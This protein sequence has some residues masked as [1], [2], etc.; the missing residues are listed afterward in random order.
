MSNAERA[1]SGNFKE[2]FRR[3]EYVDRFKNKKFFD[4][5][6]SPS[7]YH[8]N[9]QLEINTLLLIELIFRFNYSKA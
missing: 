1:P 5:W 7:D 6:T 4:P 2:I 8:W 9:F 3:T